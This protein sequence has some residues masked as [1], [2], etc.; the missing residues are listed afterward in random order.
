MKHGNR[1]PRTLSGRKLLLVITPIAAIATSMLI[2]ASPRNSRGDDQSPRCGCCAKQVIKLTEQSQDGRVFDLAFSPRRGPLICVFALHYDV[3]KW[4]M[5][6]QPH[7][8]K[9]VTPPRPMNV[10]SK[11]IGFPHPIAF[12]TDGARLAVGYHRSVQIWDFDELR[13]LF[14]VPFLWHPEAVRWS[15]IDGSLIVGC[16]YNGFLNVTGPV[17]E[18]FE[19][20]PRPEYERMKVTDPR[21]FEM[22]GGFR[23]ARRGMFSPRNGTSTAWRSIRTGRRSLPAVVRYSVAFGAGTRLRLR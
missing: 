22:D 8:V 19:V 21:N 10:S 23:E 6:A 9:T 15:P 20:L 14:A 4:D 13:L 11:P 5:S 3:E 12:S 18:K 7:K 16:S 1:T 2:T 17:P